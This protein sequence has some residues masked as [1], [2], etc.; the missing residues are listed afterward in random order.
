MGTVPI[1]F[2]LYYGMRCS[3][4]VIACLICAA[5]AA[6]GLLDDRYA[7]A[8]TDARTI[9]PTEMQVTLLTMDAGTPALQWR[10]DSGETYTLM[11]AY[12]KYPGSFSGSVGDTMILRWGKTW[13]TAAPQME[14][15]LRTADLA[16]AER[17]TRLCQLLGLPATPAYQAL[18]FMWVRPQDMFRPAY[19]SSVLAAAIVDTFPAGT[20]TPYIAWFTGYET[21]A[22]NGATKYPWTRLGYTYDWGSTSFPPAGLSEFVVTDSAIVRIAAV[23]YDYAYGMT[24]SNDGVFVYPNPYVPDDGNAATGTAASGLYFDNLMPASRLVIYTLD[25]RQVRTLQNGNTL[26]LQWDGR[27]DDGRELASGVYLYTVSGVYGTHS[28]RF[29]II[30]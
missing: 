12:T 22:Y 28:A 14:Q 29:V 27:D 2:M 13:V 25:G 19:D 5:P 9:L 11:V 16:P 4:L 30:R 3:L 1:Y 20:D 15:F 24:G 23:V 7:N 21:A 10:Y 6:A 8:V 26:R 18:V 17:N